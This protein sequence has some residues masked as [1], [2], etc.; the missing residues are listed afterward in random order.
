MTDFPDFNPT[1]EQTLQVEEPEKVPPIPVTVSDAVQVRSLPA[2]TASF[3]SV[4]L[5]ANAVRILGRDPRRKRAIISI[6]SGETIALGSTQADANGAGA[7]ISGNLELTTLD[8]VWAATW[9]TGTPS[10]VGIITEIWT[11]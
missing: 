7:P 8:E 11:D 5:T 2:K 6:A 10:T 4:D 9:G 1:V 3:E